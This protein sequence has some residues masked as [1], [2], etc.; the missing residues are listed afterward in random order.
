MCVRVYLP[1]GS[2]MQN[3]SCDEGGSK[4]RKFPSFSRDLDEQDYCGAIVPYSPR[5]KTQLTAN[6]A[7]E[8]TT[9]VLLRYL[10][11]GLIDVGNGD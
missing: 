2:K 3:L 8:T 4:V 1:E 7:Q 11:R 10:V 6:Q 9:R 5:E